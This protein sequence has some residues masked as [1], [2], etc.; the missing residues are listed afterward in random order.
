MIALFIP[1]ILNGLIGW[2][3]WGWLFV[4]IGDMQKTTAAFQDYVAWYVPVLLLLMVW[5]YWKRLPRPWRMVRKLF[6][7]SENGL[8]ADVLLSLLVSGLMVT[9]TLVLFTFSGGFAVTKPLSTTLWWAHLVG[10]VLI[11]PVTEEI[12][13]RA[14]GYWLATERGWSTA[15]GFVV[16]ALA[17]ALWHANPY[18]ILPAFLMGLVLY[19]LYRRTQSLL[20][21]VLVHGIAN[22]T[23]FVILYH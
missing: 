19:W 12:I 15:K 5:F 13:F 7:P 14:Y 6:D 11:A 9:I 16:T 10:M 4:R 8:L 3:L 23:F 17:F 1:A 18:L 21:P 2:T 20:S 22:G